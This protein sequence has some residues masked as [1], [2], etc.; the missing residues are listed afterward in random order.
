MDRAAA[1]TGCDHSHLVVGSTR[2]CSTV[3]LPNMLLSCASS[4]PADKRLY[5]Q[6]VP[7]SLKVIALAEHDGG[8]IDENGLDIDALKAYHQKHGTITGFPGAR[9]VRNPVWET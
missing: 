5:A 4:S 1:S 7:L 3:D 8:L 6:T 2:G 9:T